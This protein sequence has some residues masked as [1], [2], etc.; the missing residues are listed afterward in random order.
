MVKN[1]VKRCAVFG[2]NGYLGAHL[3]DLLRRQGAVV[4]GYDVQP[5][6]SVDTIPYVSL[7][8]MQP[9]EWAKFDPQVDFVFFFSGLTGTY[10]GFEQAQRYLQVNEGGL[11]SMLEALR[12][13]GSSAKVIF[14]STRLVYRGSDQLLTEDAPKEAKSV[15]AVNKL[16]CEGYLQAYHQSF[17]IPFTV[18][19]ICLPYGSLLETGASYGTVGFFLREARAGRNI[20]LFGDG[21]QRRTL[22]HVYDLCKV[23]LTVGFMRETCSD[24]FNVG[25]EQY[26]VRD[27]AALI[28][29]KYG[30][31]VDYREWPEADLRLESG[32][33]CFDDSLIRQ[34]SRHVNRYSFE[35][36]VAQL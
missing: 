28:A 16:A 4:T 19:R 29:R 12:K 23:V 18:F 35:S 30:V 31:G 17:G 13:S 24:V 20:T 6:H 3:A 36:W 27:I 9:D 8:V 7:D 5:A 34:R 10:Q 15:Y 33:T 11:L 21:G 14:P 1:D 32:S 25:G 26:T 22:T 2:V